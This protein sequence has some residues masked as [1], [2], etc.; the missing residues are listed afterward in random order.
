VKPFNELAVRKAVADAFPRQ[1]FVNQVLRHGDSQVATAITPALALRDAYSP[2]EAASKLDA[3]PQNPFSLADAK[4][5]LAS[6]SYPHG[7]TATLDWPN[8]GPQLGL[9]AE[10]L[11]SNLKQIGI[12]LKVTEVPIETWLGNLFSSKNG[13]NFMWDQVQT[14][15]PSEYVGFLLGPGNPSNYSNPTITSLLNSEYAQ[16]DPQKRAQEIVQ[17]NQLATTTDVVD[18]PL[19]WEPIGMA[20]KDGI[21]ISSYT[22]DTFFGPWAASVYATP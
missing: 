9:G 12:T 15:D 2:A 11:A 5:E 4:K 10:L 13:L 7:F 20:F 3:I 22:F 14:G 18:A 6:S 1:T 21:S 8:N 17:L 19:W 16:T